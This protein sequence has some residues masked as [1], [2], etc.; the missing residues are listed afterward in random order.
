MDERNSV[1]VCGVDGSTSSERA[2]EWAM[3]EASVRGCQLRVV[4]AWT[5]DGV[6][7]LVAAG[8][9]HEARERAS[10]IQEEVVARVLE[11][12]EQPPDIE[13]RFPRGVAGSALCAES[14]DAELLVLA[15][16]GHGTLY[17][18]LVGSTA[19]NVL[20]HA[21]CPVVVI[22]APS[23]QS[24]RPRSRLFRPTREGAPAIPF[25]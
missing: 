10:E 24:R 6:E 1:I 15:S 17:D 16:H 2:L 9:E 5:W 18:K 25:R 22:P 3:D 12:V 19:Q 14:M 23:H 4:T 7:D 20:R 13:R 8:S 11:H 21:T